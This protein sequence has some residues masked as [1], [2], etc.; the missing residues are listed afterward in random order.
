MLTVKQF[1]AYAADAES[2]RSINALVASYGREYAVTLEEGREISIHR[3][4]GRPGYERLPRWKAKA[5][6]KAVTDFAKTELA[7]AAA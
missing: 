3:T 5:D 7:R 1:T 2:G 4:N 6:I